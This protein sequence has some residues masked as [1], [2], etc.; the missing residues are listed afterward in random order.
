MKKFSFAFLIVAFIFSSCSYGSVEKSFMKV[1][2]VDNEN[3]KY[4]ELLN[5]DELD[6]TKKL[7]NTYF[8][9]FY[10]NYGE[11]VALNIAADTDAQ[12]KNDGIESEYEPGNI[13]IYY[14]VTSTDREEGN[15]SRKISIARDNKDKG[16]KVINQGY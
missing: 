3:I 9:D 16:W 13:I 5:E 12:Y 2:A 15:P 7:V 8:T 10:P 14:V 6:E 1:N 11:V 4:S